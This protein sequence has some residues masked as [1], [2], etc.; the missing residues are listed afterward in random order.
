MN[1]DIWH[2]YRLMTRGF[3]LPPFLGEPR[4]A[5]WL[6]EYLQRA[7]FER[8]K[9]WVSATTSREF[10]VGRAPYFRARYDAAVASGYRIRELSLDSPEQIAGLHHIVASAF[11]AFYAYT[12]IDQQE[13]ASLVGGFLRLAGT[14]LATVLADPQGKTVGFSIAFPDPMPVLKRLNGDDGWTSRW[15]AL[16]P[17]AAD[18]ALH[19]MIGVLPEARAVHSGLGSALMYDTLSRILEAG[20]PQTTFALMAD[21]S[22]ARYFAMDQAETAEREY[23][24]LERSTDPNSAVSG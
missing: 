17:P 7:G 1:F 11:D 5:P 2:G 22:P 10:L 15:R 18:R 6:P 4:N 3:Q 13:F 24:L 8:R 14:R 9:G 21:D 12:P 23:A 16:F 19:Y 20:Y